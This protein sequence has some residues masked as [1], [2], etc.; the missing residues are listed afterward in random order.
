MATDQPEQAKQYLGDY[1]AN[2]TKKIGVAPC[3]P[4]QER[5]RKL[6][7]MHV[8]TSQRIQNFLRNFSPGGSGSSQ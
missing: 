7:A 3:T 8:K 5:Q 1:I 4:C 6:N 2:L